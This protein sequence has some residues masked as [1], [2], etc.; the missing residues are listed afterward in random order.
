[1]KEVP[2]FVTTGRRTTKAGLRGQWPAGTGLN[3]LTGSACD[4]DGRQG[5]LGVD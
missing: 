5:L 4:S 1:M 3:G 2:F